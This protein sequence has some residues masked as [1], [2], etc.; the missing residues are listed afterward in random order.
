MEAGRALIVIICT[1]APAQKLSQVFQMHRST[2]GTFTKGLLYTRH[3]AE[4][5]N[6]NA[7][8]ANLEEHVLPR[9]LCQWKSGGWAT[10]YYQFP[11]FSEPTK[12]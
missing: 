7:N 1:H 10:L 4:Y 8:M 9:F 5:L 11:R 3:W 6:L 2:M 12:C